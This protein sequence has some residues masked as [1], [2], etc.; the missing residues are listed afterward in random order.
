M[1]LVNRRPHIVVS[2]EM[3]AARIRVYDGG[4]GG[5]KRN[6]NEIPAHAQRISN[7]ATQLRAY[8]ATKRDTELTSRR[9]FKVELP[10]GKSVTGST[11]ESLEESLLGK[12]VSSPAT[13]I[14]HISVLPAS[15]EDMARSLQ[16]YAN[17]ADHRGKS[18]FAV[19]ESL[20]PIPFEE[21]VAPRILDVDDATVS[22][23]LIT[24]YEDLTNK[25]T[26]ALRAQIQQEIAN[27]GGGN[28]SGQVLSSNGTILELKTSKRNIRRIT[29]LFM[30]IQSVDFNDEIVETSAQIG[31]QIPDT[32][33]VV[34]NDSNARACIFDMGVTTGSR[35]LQGSLIGQQNA[36]NQTTLPTVHNG[37]GTAYLAHGTFVASRIVFGDNIREQYLRGGFVP[38]VKVYS[39]DLRRVDG[40]G[41]LQRPSTSE[42][43][44]TIRSFVE[45]HHTEY[46]VYNL[47]VNVVN[48]VFTNTGAVS[49]LAAELDALGARYNVLFVISCGN[50]PLVGQQG[51]AEPYPQHFSNPLTAI[52]MPAESTLS[53]SVGS[54]AVNDGLGAM[55]PANQP[56]G[57][58][59]KGPGIGGDL[60]PDVI[61]HGGNNTDKWGDYEQYSATGLDES[62]S[63]LAHGNGTSYAAPL[64]TRLAAKIFN[65]FQNPSA[66]LAKALIVHFSK[67]HPYDGE[68]PD[69]KNVVGNGI[70]NENDIF[71]SHSNRQTFIFDGSL[72]FREMVEV[73]FFVP[74][75][76]TNRSGRRGLGKLKIRITIVTATETSLAL[77]SGYCKSHVRTK[78]VKINGDGKRKYVPFSDSDTLETGRYKSLYQLEK[79]FTSSVSSGEWAVFLAHES[80]WKLKNDRMRFAVVITIEDPL[81]V[82]N[83][84][85]HAAIRNESRTR[86]QADLNV[87]NRLPT[88]V[89]GRT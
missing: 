20:S 69:H 27:D 37:A 32:V 47:S 64:I 57:F 50:F 7:Q 88:R 89:R 29:D 51:P 33:T 60:K 54:C 78:I 23:F 63:Y 38:D 6:S 28:V 71:T 87:A 76:L 83:L 8:F 53:L 25:E 34:N 43:L 49:H 21:K 68:F 11:E 80:R 13:N 18:R 62:G 73:P 22:D 77:R 48:T 30:A 15:F 56:S 2:N 79:S 24:F 3:P 36:F 58:T 10:Q 44:R 86:F 5:F 41:N 55:A 81:E 35:F 40:G 85:I 72:G 17:S 61:A 82:S 52:L 67:I 66:C 42:L 84:D 65:E 45:A 39:I 16:T 19:V 74:S 14:A 12:V 4:G 1:T 31:S 70:P 26:T 46:R 59:R 9:Y 75:V